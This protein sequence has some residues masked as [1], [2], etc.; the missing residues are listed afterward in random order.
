MDRSM[1]IAFRVPGCRLE[2]L[3][4]IKDPKR[5]INE[6]KDTENF[7]KAY[8]EFKK[9]VDFTRGGFLPELDNLV[10]SMLMGVPRVPADD[11]PSED[12]EM[13]AID[14][15]VMILKAVFVEVNR[16]RE[17]GFLDQGLT[18][19]DQAGK[20]AKIVLKST[21]AEND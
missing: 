15:R 2:A 11:D 20:M 14:Q 18:R 5:R 6:M 9:T 12:A 7:I 1:E 16:D 13:A 8:H 17:D 10:W 21:N 3:S 19:Y 4:F